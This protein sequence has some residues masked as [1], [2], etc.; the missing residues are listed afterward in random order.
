[1]NIEYLSGKNTSEVVKVLSD[2]FYDYPVIRYV[3]KNKS[4]YEERLQKLV[5]F[6]IAAR[7]LRKEPIIGI[8]NSENI[9]VAAAIVTLPGDIRVPKE[10]INQREILWKE[11]GNEEQ[12]RYEKYGDAAG[13]LLPNEPHHH[14]NMIGVIPEYKGKG[15]SLKLINE[16]EKLVTSH[17]LSTGLSLITESKSN[18]KLYTHFGF[19]EIG[20]ARVDN[21]LET[22]AFFK[23]K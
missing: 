2:A 3:L 22:W 12:I 17:P 10:L 11:L 13:S 4:S 6:F 14:L 5:G 7:V 15:L 20:Y 19:N 9:L 23:S 16:V 21:N 8:Y 1:M 18:V